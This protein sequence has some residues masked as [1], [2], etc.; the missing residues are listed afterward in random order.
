MAADL[1]IH[2]TENVSDRD[3]S[4]FFSHTLG[5]RFSTG[6]IKI[7]FTPEE[8]QKANHNVGMSPNIWI[9]EVSWLKA[10]LLESPEEFIPDTVGKISEIIGEHLPII[11]DE[12]ILKIKNA[13]DLPNKTQ[14]KIAN[15]NDVINFLQ[16]HKDERCFTVSW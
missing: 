8:E 5:S 1:H 10:G 14:Y 4:I 3:L 2:T 11:N 7:R 12:L 9:G 6:F 13:F 15:E 16:E